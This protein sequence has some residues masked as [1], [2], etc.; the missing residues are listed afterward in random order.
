MSNAE[1]RL[2]NGSA[3]CQGTRRPRAGA[4]AGGCP[5]PRLAVGVLLAV[6]LAA[7]V[8]PGLSAWGSQGHGITCEIAWLRMQP[9]ARQFV[10]GLLR[11]EPRPVFNAVCTWADEV[12]DTTHPHTEAY[13]YVNIPAGAPGFDW[14][15]DC[16]RPERRCIVWAI[17]HYAGVLADRSRPLHER[18]EALKFVAHFVGDL[19]QPLH[20]GR[21]GDRGGNDIPVRLFGDPGPRGRPFNLHRVWDAELLR[22]AGREWRSS[23]QRLHRRITPQQ[24]S[25]WA[26]VDIVGWTN[27][28]FRIAEE[29]AYGELP[30]DRSIGPAYYRRALEQAE[31][32]LQKAAVRLAHLLTQAASGDLGLRIV[33]ETDTPAH[34]GPGARL[35][36]CCTRERS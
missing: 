23:A 30:P 29:V 21:L 18:A 25:E 28:S 31:Q 3:H 2:P 12:R 6:G 33:P 11:G 13:H 14:D 22:R 10:R 8:A 27:E 24:A 5:G 16:G 36:T 19:H 17:H 1:C 4:T 15:R 7:L 35:R 34:P 26:T 20:A 9:Q 32:Q